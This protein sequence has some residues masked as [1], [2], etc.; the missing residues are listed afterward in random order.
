MASL[1][2]S[3]SISPPIILFWGLSS[4]AVRYSL[5]FLSG[6]GSER[7]GTMFPGLY[8]WDRA[9]TPALTD[10]TAL[11]NRLLVTAEST[12]KCMHSH[13]FVAFLLIPISL[14][15]LTEDISFHSFF[16]AL[17]CN[18]FLFSHKRAC[19]IIQNKTLIVLLCNYYNNY[20]I[21][22]T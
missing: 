9:N 1:P 15:L 22:M 3:W 11:N 16:T 19:I 6:V 17:D 18:F 7:E 12:V 4:G 10:Y 2:L 13:S 8:T 21:I 14:F 5:H 20:F